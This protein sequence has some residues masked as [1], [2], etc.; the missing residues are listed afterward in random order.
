MTGPVAQ[1][2]DGCA[3][4]GASPREHEDDTDP[5]HDLPDARSTH[6]QAVQDR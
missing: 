3:L 6:R 2:L 4:G 1:V 5:C